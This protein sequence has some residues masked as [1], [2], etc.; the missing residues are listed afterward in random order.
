MWI[1]PE[2]IG[3]GLGKQLFT[4]VCGEALDPGYETNEF[5]ADPN[6]E[7]FYRHH[8][9]EKIDELH[10]FIFGTQRVLPR[11]RIKSKMHEQIA[12]NDAEKHAF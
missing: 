5:V 8:G 4:R 7:G 9:A 12:Q 1:E 2:Y 11:M 3:T 10:N 6:A